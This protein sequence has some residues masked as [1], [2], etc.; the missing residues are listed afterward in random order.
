MT[1]IHPGA[2][3]A[4]AP[5][6]LKTDKVFLEILNNRLSGI[7]TE[8]GRIIHRTSFTPFV[9]EAWDFGMGLVSPD[10]EMFAYPKDIGV[11]FM[12]GAPMDEAVA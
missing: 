4:T 9:K 2:E 7:V 12:V 11:A 3:D 10:G 8:M 6:A 1:S 5:H